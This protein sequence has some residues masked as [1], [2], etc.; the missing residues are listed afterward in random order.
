MKKI[1]LLLA[2]SLSAISFSQQTSATLQVGGVTR[3]YIYYQPAIYNP[4][5]DTIPVL[6]IFHG[7]GDNAA[8]MVNT[9]FNVVADTANMIPVYMDGL[10][11][12]YNQTGWNNGT[13][14]ATTADDLGFIAQVLDSLQTWYNI[15]TNRIYATGFSMGSI[16]SHH[17]ACANDEFDAIAGISGTMATSDIS[18]C[19]RTNPVRVMHMHGT[20]DATVPYSGSALP[21]L[22]LVPQTLDFWKAYSA[23]QDSVAYS[24]ENTVNDGIDVD[25]FVYNTCNPGEELEHW[26]LN[27]GEHIYPYPPVNDIFATTIIW[28]FLEGYDHGYLFGPLSTNELEKDLSIKVYPNPASSI[29]AISSE[30]E[31]ENVTIYSTNGAV[32]LKSGKYETIDISSLEAGIYFVFVQTNNGIQT[33]KIQKK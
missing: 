14:L 29:V 6:F 8:N 23:C 18:G 1:L 30:G 17:L 2:L 26:R 13:L 33:V 19:G 11:N 31:I 24:I 4:S 3:D 22:S 9:G 21:S 15:D 10:L 7:L 12:P 28:H 25:W 16:M 20:A 32:V 5:T 27:G